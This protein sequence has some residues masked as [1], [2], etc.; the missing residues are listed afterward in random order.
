MSERT[1]GTDMELDLD[2]ELAAVRRR[3]HPTGAAKVREVLRGAATRTRLALLVGGVIL[4]A[5]VSVVTRPRAD[6]AAVPI[7]HLVVAGLG[8][9]VVAAVG[10]ALWLRPAYRNPLS[11][12]VV[13][14][15][16][17]LGAATV[18]AAEAMPVHTDHPASLGGVGD[19]LWSEAWPCLLYG[20]G[21]A[22]VPLLLGVFL[23]RGALA[24]STPGTRAML[25][26]YAGAAGL[27]GLLVHCPLTAVAHR[28]V[29]HALLIVPLA[30][31][32]G[33]AA[34]VR[35]DVRRG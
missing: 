22:S 15:L 30:L 10:A 33:L 18:V 20:A 23:S 12:T 25:A 14:T 31:G 16:A 29:G 4:A 7:L 34:L 2:S 13:A 24:Q 26:L 1:Q 9:V 11:R 8:L 17:V 5:V 27:A 3:V 32:L 21:Y 19:H 35:R 6:L 28:L